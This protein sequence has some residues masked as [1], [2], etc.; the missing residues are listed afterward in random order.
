MKIISK[1]KDYYDFEVKY[2]GFDDSRVYDRRN[3]NPISSVQD[4]WSLFHICGN[5]YPVV[6]KHNKFYFEPSKEL[7]HDDN[8]FIKD[9][10]GYSTDINF[11]LQ[12]PVILMHEYYTKQWEIPILANY[13]FASYINSR[14]MYRM[15]YDYLG[16]MKDNPPIPDNQS[17][18]EKVSSHGFDLKRSFR[19]KMKK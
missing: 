1:H 6:K 16:W 13:G 4:E 12:Q 19:P 9:N 7:D 14:K 8:W 18:K 3:K 5:Q 17:D 10:S 11:K 2:F 15:I